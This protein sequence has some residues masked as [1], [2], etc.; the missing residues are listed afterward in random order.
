MNPRIAR[1]AAGTCTGGQFART[2]HAESGLE[3]EHYRH[4]LG[5]QPSAAPQPLKNYPARSTVHRRPIRK[6]RVFVDRAHS[7]INGEPAIYAAVASK[8]KWKPLPIGYLASA[9]LDRRTDTAALAAK[10]LRLTVADRAALTSFAQLQI[11]DPPDA[12]EVRTDQA[13]QAQAAQRRTDR[14]SRLR[15]LLSRAG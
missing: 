12:E 9:I 6:H 10:Q 15:S 14:R 1:Q 13:S 5:D 3:F 2:S 8:G 4:L 7:V 11:A